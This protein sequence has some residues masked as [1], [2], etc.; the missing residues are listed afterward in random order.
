MQFRSRGQ[1]HVDV[2]LF[3]F[4]RLTPL[5]LVAVRIF[6]QHVVHFLL[7]NGL[8]E[9]QEYLRENDSGRPVELRSA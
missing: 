1:I 5:Y 4:A 7:A 2:G 8:K 9:E 6:P 3:I